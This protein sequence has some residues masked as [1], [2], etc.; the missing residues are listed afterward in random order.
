MF[1]QEGAHLYREIKIN[2]LERKEMA[3]GPFPVHKK[4]F[5]LSSEKTTSLLALQGAFPKLAIQNHI[6]TGKTLLGPFKS[7]T[8]QTLISATFSTIK[9]RDKQKKKKAGP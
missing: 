6:L 1:A 9:P 4:I 5:S 2:T 7:L 8:G 3:Q